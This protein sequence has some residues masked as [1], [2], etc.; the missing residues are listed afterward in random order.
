M[1]INENVFPESMVQIVRATDR[2]TGKYGEIVYS[3]E[4]QGS[5]AFTIDPKHGHI[6]VNLYFFHLF[7]LHFLLFVY[8]ISVCLQVKAV[9]SASGG[10][11]NIDRERQAEYRLN[12]IATDTPNGGAE[13]RSNR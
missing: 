10:R 3:I 8:I 12:I 9:N 2:D 5:D 11:S 4:G 13:Q 6:Q 7:C 1:S